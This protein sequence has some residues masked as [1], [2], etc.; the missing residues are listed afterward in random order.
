L[1]KAKAKIDAPVIKKGVLL[2]HPKGGGGNVSRRSIADVNAIVALFMPKTTG[3]CNVAIHLT[4]GTKIFYDEKT[5]TKPNL[6]D[7]IM[8]F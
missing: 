2:R 4:A 8:F 5:K 7:L 1:G 3:G 6:F